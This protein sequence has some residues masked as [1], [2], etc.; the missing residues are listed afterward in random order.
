MLLSRFL[1]LLLLLAP[2]A[3]AHDLYSLEGGY[4]FI[5]DRASVLVS[6]PIKKKYRFEIPRS[7]FNQSLEWSRSVFKVNSQSGQER[8][9]A[10]V[11]GKNLVLT[12][13]H[14]FDSQAC[15]QFEV[16][17]PNGTPRAQ[18]LDV[19]VCGSVYDF[20]LVRVKNLDA[21]IMSLKR[22]MPHESEILTL[23]GNSGGHVLSASQA[24]GAQ[25]KN[26]N[27]LIHSMENDHGSSGGP[28][29]NSEGEVVALHFGTDRSEGSPTQG[30]SLGIIM[31]G[32]LIELDR[33]AP[34][35]ILELAWR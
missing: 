26:Q 15:G 9:T 18:C 3:W 5:E 22:G 13:R 31:D 17:N 29:L 28:I 32:L 4:Q 33:L 11:V 19:I 27:I 34:D 23:I 20:C 30:L 6:H 25:I 10:F 2:S 35:L 14:L 12:N 16:L 21:P 1:G 8:G 24:T 7:D